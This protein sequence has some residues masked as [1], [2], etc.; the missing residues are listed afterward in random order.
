M[1]RIKIFFRRLFGGSFKRMFKQ[2]ELIHKE[3]GANRFVMFCG[4]CIGTEF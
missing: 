2:I 3:T 1:N 4:N